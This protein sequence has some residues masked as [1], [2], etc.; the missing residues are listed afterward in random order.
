MSDEKAGSAPGK[1]GE[2]HIRQRP[3][4]VG[5]SPDHGADHSGMMALGGR[6]LLPCGQGKH[7]ARD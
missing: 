6:S 1:D 7:G 4:M 3:P 5:F 2:F